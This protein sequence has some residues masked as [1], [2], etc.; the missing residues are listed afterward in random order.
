MP[1]AVS[2]NALTR[3]L[4]LAMVIFGVTAIP[5]EAPAEPYLAV[6]KG[7]HCSSCHSHAAGGGKRNA[8][9]NVFAQTEL[10]ANRIGGSDSGL[11]TGAVSEWFAVGANLRG[12]YNYVDTPNADS[13]NGFDITRATLYFE[14]NVIANRLS[15]YVDQQVAPNSSINREAYVKLK[16]SAGR[17]RLTAGQF[18]IPYGLRLQDDSAFV[19]LATGVNFTNPD[20]GVQVVYEDGPWSAIASVTNGTA[21]GAEIDSGKQTSLMATYVRSRWR[22]GFSFNDNNADAGDRQMQ[23]LFFGLKTGP[24]VWLGEVD[25]IEDELP[26]SASQDSIAGLIEGNWLYRKGHNLKVSYEYFDPNDDVDEDHQARWSLVWEHS[27][28]QFLQARLGIRLYDGVPQVDVQNRDELFLE[29]HGF[30]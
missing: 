12:G 6:D 28:I 14:G 30:F 18:Y 17:W 2:M 27:P 4:Y 8:Y 15:V 11:W 5:D 23:N 10:A 22:A 16:S 3:G 1:A 7:L 29:I 13:R 26:G 21:A 25:R 9:G 24:V 19:R 20:R